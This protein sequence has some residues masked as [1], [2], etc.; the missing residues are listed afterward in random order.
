MWKEISQFHPHPK[1]Y[2]EKQQGLGS[3]SISTS[4]IATGAARGF[5]RGRGEGSKTRLFPSSH[6][7]QLNQQLQYNPSPSGLRIP[8]RKKLSQLIQCLAISETQKMHLESQLNE[9]SR[10]KQE[11]SSKLEVALQYKEDILMEQKSKSMR[12]PRTFAF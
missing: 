11:L 2:Y 10:E 8:N 4:S 3:G 1:S 9:V 12:L 7:Q 6:Q 5:R